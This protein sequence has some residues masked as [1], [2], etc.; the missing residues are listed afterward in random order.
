MPQVKTFHARVGVRGRDGLIKV[1]CANLPDYS[2]PGEILEEL[3]AYLGASTAGEIVGALCDRV[4]SQRLP[5]D[6]SDLSVSD[7]VGFRGEV[8]DWSYQV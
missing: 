4:R 8:V 1:I 2:S 3:G 5:S 6:L 7:G